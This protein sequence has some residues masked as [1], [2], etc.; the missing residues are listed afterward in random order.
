MKQRMTPWV[1]AAPRKSARVKR[2]HA[3]VIMEEGVIHSWHAL[4]LGESSFW[5][6][7]LESVAIT[8]EKQL[9]L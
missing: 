8:P 2:A 9:Q 5:S 1:A 3:Y 4:D 7:D 6:M